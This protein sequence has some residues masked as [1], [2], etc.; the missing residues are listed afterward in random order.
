MMVAD[1]GIGTSLCLVSLLHM[2]QRCFPTFSSRETS[3]YLLQ[4]LSRTCCPAFHHVSP[5]QEA[6]SFF[7]PKPPR[8]TARPQFHCNSE[9]AEVFAS[10][11]LTVTFDTLFRDTHTLFFLVLPLFMVISIF[12]HLILPGHSA[13]LC[14]LLSL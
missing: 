14:T 8:P 3:H 13:G 6:G 7:S 11:C 2:P 10:A 9:K 12:S 5:F 4:C 1:V